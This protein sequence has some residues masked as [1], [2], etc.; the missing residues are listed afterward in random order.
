MKRI[1]RDR[2]KKSNIAQSQIIG[3]DK[4]ITD[5]NQLITQIKQ[6]V[7]NQFDQTIYWHK[8]LVN[9]KEKFISKKKSKSKSKSKDNLLKII[10]QCDDKQDIVVKISNQVL[11]L[12]S[13]EQ[14][15]INFVSKEF[16]KIKKNI[17]EF[18]G[19]TLEE[20]NAVTS[21][22]RNLKP[23]NR[24]LDNSCGDSKKKNLSD[25]IKI[26]DS[27][28]SAEK[29]HSMIPETTTDRDKP[30]VIITS[31]FRLYSYNDTTNP[32]KEFKKKKKK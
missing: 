2:K 26:L 12:L 10:K 29:I 18:V 15:N 31:L 20:L 28:I 25:N 27:S 30:K 7:A 5:I 3:I 16:A 14:K 9:Y 1:I 21:Q 8:K 23:E 13:K 11:N 22:I 6:I 19:E 4:K 32:Q 17:N 24:Y